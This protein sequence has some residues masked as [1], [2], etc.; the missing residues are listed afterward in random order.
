MAEFSIQVYAVE[1]LILANLESLYESRRFD[2][3][4]EYG[5][6]L[7]KNPDV[8][9]REERIAVHCYLGFSY[10]I[11]RRELEAKHHFMQWLKLEPEAQLDPI[12]V[13]PNIIRVFQLAKDALQKESASPLPSA[14]NLQDRWL[15]MKPAISR[16]LIFPGWG[17]YY[18]GQK[19]KGII[20]I[21]AETT[22][23][24][25]SIVSHQNFLQAERAY[26]QERDI[27]KM[28]EKYRQYQYANRWQWSI[29]TG[30]IV[31]YAVTQY[32]IIN[33]KIELGINDTS[34]KIGVYP[35]YSA[36]SSLSIN[37]YF[38]LE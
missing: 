6:E 7:L 30:A 37:L 28:N 33:Q 16:S 24:I 32:D 11:L 4:V 14:R 23:I 2:E 25:G 15:W 19:T 31:L 22:L 20:I 26:Y 17:H 21:S 34:F 12:L 36:D 3:L 18:R 35:Q 29:I 8:L 10:V 38:T 13:P 5:N 9:Y 27:T 1:R